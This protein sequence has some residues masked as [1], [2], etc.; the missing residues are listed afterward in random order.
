MH[1]RF[2]TS[3]GF[4]QKGD[5]ADLTPGIAEQV[6]REGRAVQCAKPGQTKAHLIAELRTIANREPKTPA[7]NRRL[8]KS[9]ILALY[10]RDFQGKPYAYG[11]VHTLK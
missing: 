5:V 11:R 6:I 9:E 10:K 4:Y 8:T 1:V 7:G 2:I 3:N